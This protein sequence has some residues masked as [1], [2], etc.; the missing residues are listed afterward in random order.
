[1][2]N[3]RPHPLPPAKTRENPPPITYLNPHPVP[4]ATRHAS[5]PVPTDRH[6]DVDL[7]C[8]Q[9]GGLWTT[10]GAARGTVGAPWDDGTGGR[11]P[12]GLP[13]SFSSQRAVPWVT[14]S[15]WLTFRPVT[16]PA[17]CAVTGFSIFMASSTTI[18]SPG[19]TD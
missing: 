5:L 16:V 3:Q 4:G 1:M 8:G 9:P 2:V 14:V 17:L 15:P 13:Q 11:R 12:P 7:A 19:S 6:P 10:R 18:R